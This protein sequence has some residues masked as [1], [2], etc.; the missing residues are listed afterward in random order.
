M[1]LESQGTQRQCSE[2]AL[3]VTLS[4]SCLIAAA[5]LDANIQPSQAKDQATE[6]RISPTAEK[7]K[8][9]PAQ[10][11][12]SAAAEGDLDAVRTQLDA[13]VPVDAADPRGNTA[14][15]L[16]T[17]R[18][19]VDVARLLIERGASVNHQNDM[20]DSA[21]LLAGALGRLDILKLALAHGAD[22]RSTNRYG[23]TALIPACERGH[24]D[25][26]RMLIAAGVNVDHVNRL[27]WTG[28]LEAVVLG[29]GS[30][31]YQDIVHQL[32]MAGANPNLA[33]KDGVT[34]LAHAREKGQDVV[35]G[36]LQAVGGH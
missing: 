9:H 6:S 25:A 16:A 21:Y 19:Q 29:D 35:A 4:L 32:L 10:P 28:L 22:L 31:R 8:P 33:D 30:Q 7:S 2:L 13:G 24:V 11:L 34:P 17:A 18:D 1:K 14:L 36:M 15:L 23:G 27:G 12:W 26:V 3:T 5:F 20:L